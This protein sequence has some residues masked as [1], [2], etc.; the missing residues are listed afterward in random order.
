MVDPAPPPATDPAPP[1]R[2]G[3]ALGAAARRRPDGGRAKWLV[4]AIFGVPVIVIGLLQV[5]GVLKN[6]VAEKVLERRRSQDAQPQTPPAPAEPVRH[7]DTG[8]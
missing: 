4:W 2:L 5:F 7:D 6:P 3:D 1:R 8:M